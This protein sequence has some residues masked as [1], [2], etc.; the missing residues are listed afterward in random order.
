MSG[1][2]AA[3]SGKMKKLFGG[4]DAGDVGFEFDSWNPAWHF[5]PVSN[6]QPLPCPSG[7]CLTWAISRVYNSLLD[8]APVEALASDA[9]A[10]KLLINLLGDLHQPL[11]VVEKTSETAKQLWETGLVEQIQ[12]T[13]GN[14]WWSGWSHV[15]LI[16]DSF[17]EEKRKFK[18]TGFDKMLEIWTNES[19]QIAC[20]IIS[21]KEAQRIVKERILIAGARTAIVLGEIFAARPA[22]AF[23]PAANKTTNNLPTAQG[24]AKNLIL[25]A[26][27]VLVFFVLVRKTEG[28]SEVQPTELTVTKL[29]E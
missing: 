15:N 20:K 5:Q 8:G 24:P 17:A 16:A 7:A 21:D 12:T 29:K 28:A 4:Q 1:L 25:L 3:S 18:E 27:V 22:S 10:V 19:A 6:C 9:E 23:R 11:H 2:D 13:T 26:V 14:F